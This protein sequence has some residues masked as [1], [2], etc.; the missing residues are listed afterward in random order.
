[1]VGLDPGHVQVL[2]E[3]GG[4]WPPVL[5]WGPENQIVDGHHRVAA[6]RMLGLTSVEVEWF[7]GPGR[8]DIDRGDS[9]KR[10]AWVAPHASG[11]VAGCGS[12]VGPATAVVGSADRLVMWAYGQDGGPYPT[13][14]GRGVRRDGGAGGTGR[15]RRSCTSG[16][17]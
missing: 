9:P 16:S 10:E 7:E 3:V 2:A 12:G 6:A 15:H 1:M 13:Q 11:S 4:R 14:A 5:V 8:G 17:S